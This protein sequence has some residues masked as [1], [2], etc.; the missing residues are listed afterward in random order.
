MKYR[1][2]T[3]CKRWLASLR[4]IM[5]LNL[6]LARYDCTSSILLLLRRDTQSTFTSKL[7]VVP[8]YTT[9][10]IAATLLHQLRFPLG[11]QFEQTTSLIA[12]FSPDID[13]DNLG[14]CYL[15]FH[16][17]PGLASHLFSLVPRR[18]RKSWIEASFVYST[19]F[20]FFI[21]FVQFNSWQDDNKY[22][23]NGNL[24]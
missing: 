15:A 3:G 14:L 22:S 21:S 10:R 9:L 4:K 6:R 20:F 11:S 2:A 23:E 8:H 12:F 24:E 19:T 5:P 13:I 16:D 1:R 17:Y 7:L 18:T